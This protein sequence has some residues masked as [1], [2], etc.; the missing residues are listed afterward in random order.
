MTAALFSCLATGREPSIRN[1]REMLLAIAGKGSRTT[2]VAAFLR[3]NGKHLGNA[4]ETLRET[5]RETASVLKTA[6][7]ETPRE[8][9]REAVGKH[10]GNDTHAGAHELSVFVSGD[11]PASLS[12]CTSS[13]RSEVPSDPKNAQQS[14]L[15]VAGPAEA[16]KRVEASPLT[17][18]AYAIR[19]RLSKLVAPHLEGMTLKTW[20]QRNTN[21]AREMAE[22]GV[23]ADEAAAAWQARFDLTGRPVVVLKYLHDDLVAERIRA[24]NGNGRRGGASVN[25][26]ERRDGETTVAAIAAAQAAKRERLLAKAPPPRKDEDHVHH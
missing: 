23:T 14:L 12:S 26:Y 5:P 21:T 9:P 16:R 20:R 6:D 8:T 25:D 4:W 22:A 13:L 18:A 24:K 2:D 17:V 3:A 7:R 1:V 15:P 19:D 10:S 11:P